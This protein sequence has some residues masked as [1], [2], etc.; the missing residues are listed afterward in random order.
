MSQENRINKIVWS[1]SKKGLSRF[2]FKSGDNPWGIGPQNSSQKQK[3]CNKTASSYKFASCLTNR[4]YN[5]YP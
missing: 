5:L 2:Y 4:T 3:F 1:K